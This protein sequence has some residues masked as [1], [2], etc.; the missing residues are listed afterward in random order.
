MTRFI[1]IPGKTE[2]GRPDKKLM[3]LFV[4]AKGR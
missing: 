2:K 4:A 1:S 3:V